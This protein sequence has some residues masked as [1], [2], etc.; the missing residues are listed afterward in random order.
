VIRQINAGGTAVVAGRA[1]TSTGDGPGS[2]RIYIMSKGMSNGKDSQSPEGQEEI[3]KK[4]SEF[5]G[6]E[7]E[8]TIH[9]NEARSVVLW[10]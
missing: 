3:R 7:V 5:R 4:I 1:E 9:E 10:V 2:Q 6:K 8:R